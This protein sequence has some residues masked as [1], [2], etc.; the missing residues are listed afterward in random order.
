[1]PKLEAGKGP[2]DAYIEPPLR[3]L[4]DYAKNG[5][6]PIVDE[7]LDVKTE[8]WQD[9]YDAA[10][11]TQGVHFPRIGAF[12]SGFMFFWV[13]GMSFTAALIYPGKKS[14]YLGLIRMGL[15]LPIAWHVYV[16]VDPL[17]FLT[18]RLDLFWKKTWRMARQEKLSR[19]AQ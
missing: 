10:V 17:C 4:D 14:L 11:Y 3:W 16:T 18:E 1:M 5:Y 9:D 2:L 6:R 12:C 19:D 13:L 7:T 15:A 8:R